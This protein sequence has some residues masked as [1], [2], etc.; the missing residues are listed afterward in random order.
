MKR[1]RSHWLTA[2]FIVFAGCAVAILGAGVW[3]KRWVPTTG[4]AW[5]EA[6][7]E[8]RFAKDV[9]IGALR[10]TLWG[11]LHFED[12][13]VTD[14]STSITWFAA[15]DLK[16]QVGWLRLL[17]QRQVAFSLTG[18]L[19][20]PA[21]T[22]VDLS[23]RYDLRARQG[24][25]TI[26]T[27]AIPI[28]RLIPEAARLLPPALKAGQAQLKGR[29]TWQRDTLP[30]FSGQLIGSQFV[31]SHEALRIA[32]DLRADGTIEPTPNAATPWSVD[33][34]VHVGRAT[35]EGLPFLRA[36]DDIRGV[37]HVVNDTLE[38]KRLSGTSQGSPWQME[39]TIVSWVSPYAE[40]AVQ[41][42]VDLSRLS[43][44]DLDIPMT[45]QPTG[46]AELKAVCRGW[47]S[48]RPL[49]ELMAN[50]SIHDASL[51]P[52]AWPTRVE[53]LEGTFNYDHLTRQMTIPAL[54]GRLEAQTI[55][56]RGSVR[57][58]TP[59]VLDLVAETT[60]DL[61]ALRPLI[62]DGHPIQELVGPMT[63]A[64]HVSGPMTRVQWEGHG[65]LQDARMSLRG[66]PKPIDKLNGTIAFTNQQVSTTRLS[67]TID[68]QPIVLTGQVTDLTAIPTI[69][70]HAQIAQ[71]SVNAK[72]QWHTDRVLVETLEL[73]V[74][75]SRLTAHGEIGRLPHQPKDMVLTGT[76]Q[77]ADLSQIPW[78]NL[79]G[80]EAWRLQGEATVQARVAASLG[81]LSSTQT[82]GVVRAEMITVRDLPI[83]KV[84]AELEQGQGRVAIRVTDATLGGGRLV[85]D[86]LINR[87]EQPPRYLLEFDV[88]KTDLA[89]L[90][91]AI[92]AWRDRQ[93]A[94]EV[95]AH[96]RLTGVWAHR[97]SLRGEGWVHATG[98]RLGNLPLLD[99]L[100]RGFFG[101]LADRLG[102][103]TLRSAQ[104]TDLAAQWH[105]ANERIISDDL[106]LRGVSGT[107]PVAIYVRGS[108]GL[109]KTLDLTVEPDL[110]EQ[111]VLRAPNTSAFSSALLKTVGGLE[112]LRR[113]VGRH[114]LTGTI[115]K[116]QYKFEFSLDQLFNQ[117]IPSGLQQL[118]DALR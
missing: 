65:T 5:L 31:W 62:P 49:M 113:L 112:R 78:M 66:V 106:R 28:E 17:V 73:A 104:I 35:I 107:E 64:V 100:L 26:L 14:P 47:L 18:S 55:T 105:L 74:G 76:M 94:G 38:I 3:L 116:P 22:T 71:T 42:R 30:I 72:A 27:S 70:I 63:G 109:D 108:I 52:P 45:W 56:L 2:W 88:T 91:P 81:Q 29:L 53:H 85:G 117:T 110:S 6:R 58:T 79:K 8:Q 7:L 60:G 21:Q 51:S 4:K 77:L 93:I 34:S 80:V 90:A 40:L 50:A 97:A 20:A 11:E 99:R 103:A 24:V 25:V 54:T 69:L 59:A 98:E 10:A 102:L 95:S 39:G 111:L 32:G 89:Q 41:T 16:A 101:A 84:T 36:A 12:V 23:G 75:E 37:L 48:R 96:A 15:S 1:A 33:L 114:R 92:P 46:T 87:T 43:T 13:R 57:L 19:T 118:F 68:G 67:A 9:S 82:S 44:F 86:S 115:E 61:G 83:H